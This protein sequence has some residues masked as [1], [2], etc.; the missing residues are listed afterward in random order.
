VRAVALARATRPDVTLEIAGQGDDASA[1]GWPA[2]WVRAARVRSS[3]SSR[4]SEA[5]PAATGLGVVLP[6]RRRVGAS[7]TSRQRRAARPRWRRTVPGCVSRCGT[8]RRVPGAARRRAGAGR[9]AGRAR[10]RPALTARLGRGAARLRRGNCRGNAPHGP[11]KPIS[12]ASSLRRSD[13]ADHDH[14]TPLRGTASSASGRAGGERLSRM[15][16]R[17]HDAQVLF[18]ED[19]GTPAVEVAGAHRARGCARGRRGGA[20]IT[21]PRSTRGG[22][23]AAPARQGA[24]E[25]NEAAPS[26]TARPCWMRAR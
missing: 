15:A 11:R 6:V 20:K 8:A 9:P 19:H 22:Q 23:G 5:P 17:P 4:R 3:G 12:S 14:R 21:A 26:G 24:A 13:H 1:R 16:T 25:A 18:D 7:P 10:G 2:R